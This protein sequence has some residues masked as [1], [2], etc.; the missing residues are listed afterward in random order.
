MPGDIFYK[1]REGGVD[2]EY[3]SLGIDDQPVL[4]GRTGVQVYSDFM[5]AYLST[6]KSYLGSTIE[7]VQ[8]GL[9]PAGGRQCIVFKTPHLV[10]VK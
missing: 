5:K 6:F 10:K 8:I 7:A 9:G 2:Q 1:D 4:L 3:L